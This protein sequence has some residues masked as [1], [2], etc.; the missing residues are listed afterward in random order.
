MSNSFKL[1]PTLLY[2][3]GGEEFFQGVFLPPYLRA[4]DRPKRCLK[5]L[6]RSL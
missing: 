1:G 6:Q 3:P 4:C 5:C 2:F